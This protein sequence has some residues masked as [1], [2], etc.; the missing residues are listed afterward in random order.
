MTKILIIEDETAVRENLLELLEAEDFETVSAANGRSGLELAHSEK[1]DL[2]LCDMMMPE[3]DGYGVLSALRQEVTT[4]AIPF[5]FLTAKASKLDFRQGMD[6]GADDYLTKPFTRAEL[7]SAILS[8]LEKQANLKKYLDTKPEIKT[9]FPGIQEIEAKL[10]RALQQGNLEEFQVN[11]QPV[12]DINS[13]EIIAA[14]SL[15]RWQSPEL[16][17]ISPSEL[18]PLAESTGLMVP[19]GEWILQRTCKQTKVWHNLGFWGLKIAVNLSKQQFYQPNLSQK[20]TDFLAENDLTA[21]SLELEVTETVIMQNVNS[22]IA[23]MKQLQSL[24]IKITIDDFGTGNSTLIC[25]KQLPVNSLKIDRYFIKNV[26]SDPEKSAITSALIKM[27][28][29]LNLHVV[30]KGV[31]SPSELGFLRQHQCDAMQGF[32]F[33]HPI[34]ATELEKLLLSTK[35]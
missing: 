1:P 23:T 27:A 9:F 24:G 32:L 4:T 29:N 22:A 30:A 19:I 13:G 14:E 34:P 15:L 35:N 11:Y 8:R 7:L 12:V 16:G 20:I 26:D 17:L 25:L 18:I 28:K 5:I 6:L 10:R 21:H 33:S 2:I 31:E 3:I